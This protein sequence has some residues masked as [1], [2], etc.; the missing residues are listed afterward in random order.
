MSREL[1]GT[2]SLDIHAEDDLRPRRIVNLHPRLR[3]RIRRQ[4]QQQS[5]ID[6]L[7]AL[8]ADAQTKG[9]ITIKR[10]RAS[11]PETVFEMALRKKFIL[12]SYTRAAL[13][14]FGI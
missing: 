2:H 4:H 5:P 10:V 6:R 8:G 12:G 14:A 1:A 13:L 9:L 11:F 3:R 7:G